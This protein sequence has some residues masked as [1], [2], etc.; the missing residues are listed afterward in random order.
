MFV[1][2]DL[3]FERKVYDMTR[4]QLKKIIYNNR[5]IRRAM[6]GYS[7]MTVDEMKISYISL[8]YWYCYAI[9]D[10]ESRRFDVNDLFVTDD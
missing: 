3:D 6:R 4:E 10:N 1:N 5:V 7:K 9:N 8:Y 2:R